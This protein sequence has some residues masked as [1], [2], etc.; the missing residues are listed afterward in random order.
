[1]KGILY[2]GAEPDQWLGFFFSYRDDIS[3]KKNW[4]YDKIDTEEYALKR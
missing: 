2:Q 4:T 1:M 3:W